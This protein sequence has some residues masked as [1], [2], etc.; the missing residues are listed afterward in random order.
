MYLVTNVAALL[1]TESAGLA[2][3]YLLLAAVVSFEIFYLCLDLQLTT[4][5]DMPECSPVQLILLHNHGFIL[6][7]VVVF[8]TQALALGNAW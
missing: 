8:C 7:D 1:H 3:I 2:C 6:F 4:V 5:D